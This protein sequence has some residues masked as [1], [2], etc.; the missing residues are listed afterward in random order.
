MTET[1]N[2]LIKAAENALDAK[3]RYEWAFYLVRSM[4]NEL[5]TKEQTGTTAFLVNAANEFLEGENNG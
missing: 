4:R 2:K 1:T 5:A 3:R